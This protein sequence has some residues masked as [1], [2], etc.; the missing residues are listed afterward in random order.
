MSRRGFDL[1]IGGVILL[2]LA[3]KAPLVLACGLAYAWW[4]VH[5]SPGEISVEA[6]ARAAMIG[7]FAG[8]LLFGLLF[9][10]VV[11]LIA[12]GGSLE[13]TRDFLHEDANSTSLGW[14]LMGLSAL[15]QSFFLGLSIRLMGPCLPR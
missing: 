13:F 2:V 4:M 6:T 1:L 14:F 8:R 15:V 12:G 3:L 7:G 5:R 11:P 10:A 9:F